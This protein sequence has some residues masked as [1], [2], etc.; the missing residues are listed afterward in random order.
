M[1][2]VF[3]RHVFR[4]STALHRYTFKD[5]IGVENATSIAQKVM[6][7]SI[8]IVKTTEYPPGRLFFMDANSHARTITN[9]LLVP[10]TLDFPSTH[11]NRCSVTF[12]LGHN[13][14]SQKMESRLRTFFSTYKK[15]SL[16]LEIYSF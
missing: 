6:F 10:Y 14:C 16:Y 1:I 8:G 13:S 12:R 4:L 5:E 7:V 2:H 15:Y 9:N 11:P 3:L